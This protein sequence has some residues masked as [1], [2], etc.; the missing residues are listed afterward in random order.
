MTDKFDL[1]VEA[2]K[3]IANSDPMTVDVV[4]KAKI[5]LS[6][7]QYLIEQEDKVRFWEMLK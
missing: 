7:I 3:W 5:T 4:G 2:L 1:A 6:Q